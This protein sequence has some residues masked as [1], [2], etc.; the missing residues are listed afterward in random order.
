MVDRYHE[1]GYD[2]LAIADHNMVTYPWQE[3]SSFE[4]SRRIYIRLEEG[5]LNGLT[6]EDVFVYENRDPASTGMIAIQ[7]NE[8]SQ[9]HHLGSYFNDHPGGILETEEETLA[10]IDATNGLAVL[11]H[12][13]RLNR[14]ENKP[15]EWYVDMF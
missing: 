14:N 3:F 2:I 7:A 10:A 6:Y 13:G 9:H 8:V 4:A 1:L 5:Q 11:F 12:P 15:V